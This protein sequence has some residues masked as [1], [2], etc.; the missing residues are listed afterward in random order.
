MS[1]NTDTDTDTGGIQNTDT[2][3]WLPCIPGWPDPDN[4][5]GSASAIIRRPTADCSQSANWTRSTSILGRGTTN[6]E[7]SPCWH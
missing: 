6:M 7:L 1:E 2:D 5:S 4:C 3:P